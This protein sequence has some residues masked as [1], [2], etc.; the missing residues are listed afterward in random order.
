MKLENQVCTLVQA[1]KLKQLGVTQKGAIFFY[2]IENKL[3]F[4]DNHQF[5]VDQEFDFKSSY[6]AFTVAELGVMFLP[7][8]GIYSTISQPSGE[9]CICDVYENQPAGDG[10]KTEAEARAA[11]IIEMLASKQITVE[12]LNKR[13]LKS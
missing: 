5:E 9:W 3:M 6:S 4:N 12:D 10:F 1:K 11:F 7:K 8:D 13:L 2:G